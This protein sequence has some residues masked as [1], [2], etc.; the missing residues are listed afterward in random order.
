MA[1]DADIVLHD[2]ST[3]KWRILF[4]RKRE[5]WSSGVEESLNARPDHVTTGLNIRLICLYSILLRERQDN[6]DE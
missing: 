2:S 1:E 5:M 3:T 4:K 6:R